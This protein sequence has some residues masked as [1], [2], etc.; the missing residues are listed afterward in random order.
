ML[1]RHVRFND[2]RDRGIVKSWA[3]L[4]NLVEKCGFPCGQMLSPNARVWREDEVLAWLDSRPVDPK[5]WPGAR[6]GASAA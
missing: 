4:K 1:P 3:Q 2:L 5:P 6:A